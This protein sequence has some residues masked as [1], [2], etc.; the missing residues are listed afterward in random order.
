M[1]TA[2]YSKM[3]EEDFDEILE[4]IVRNMSA[5]SILGYGD[6]YA[7]LR[8]ELNNEVLE[9]WERENPHLAFPEDHPADHAEIAGDSN[10]GWRVETWS[11]DHRLTSEHFGHLEIAKQRLAEVREEI[12]KA[13]PVEA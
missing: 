13:E 10:E 2:D 4:S 12:A 11:G 8:E 9:A 3:S 6:V 5:A 7:I 1:K